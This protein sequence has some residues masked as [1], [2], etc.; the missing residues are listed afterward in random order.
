MPLFKVCFDV[1]PIYMRLD[2][3]RTRC[4]FLNNVYI[5]A[6]SKPEA[7]SAARVRLNKSL[8]A[9][10][11]K[12]EIEFSNAEVKVDSVERSGQLWKLVRPEGFV[13]YRQDDVS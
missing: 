3:V 6:P 4:G 13:F 2:G 5:L 10:A 9:R 12:G 7:V 11:E 1:S 8:G